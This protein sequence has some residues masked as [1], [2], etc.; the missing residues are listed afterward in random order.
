MESGGN[1]WGARPH[2]DDGPVVEAIHINSTLLRLSCRQEEIAA[3]SK[4]VRYDLG[5]S[6]E[7]RVGTEQ[8]SRKQNHTAEQEIS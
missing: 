5:I 7:D 1:D 3:Q 2:H 8:K 4:G 6:V